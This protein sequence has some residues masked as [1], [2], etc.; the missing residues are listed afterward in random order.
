MYPMLKMA[1]TT[2]KIWHLKYSSCDLYCFRYFHFYS[3]EFP[4]ACAG[5]R[6]MEMVLSILFCGYW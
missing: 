2:I 4:D 6:K 5:C 1:H 3:K